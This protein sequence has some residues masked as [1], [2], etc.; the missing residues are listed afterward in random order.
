MATLRANLLWVDSLAGLTVGILVL[1]LRGWLTEWY[2]LPP[3]FLLLMGV[4][5]VVYGCFSF[6]LALRK[7]RPEA[8][9]IV[10]IVANLVWAVLCVWWGLAYSATASPL[11][12]VQLF[13]EA[14][15]VGGLACLEWRWFDALVAAPTGSK[16]I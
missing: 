3:D 16:R 13:G 15:F 12:L 8:L 6:T 14:V 9:L 5:N 2:Q 7:Q 10:L 11:G 1:T 4:A